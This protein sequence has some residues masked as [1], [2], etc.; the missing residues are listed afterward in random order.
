MNNAKLCLSIRNVIRIGSQLFKG[1]LELNFFK[2][3]SL[4]FSMIM[5]FV[6]CSS[7]SNYFNPGG[8][9]LKVQVMSYKA[10][11]FLIIFSTIFLMTQK[12]R[13]YWD[14]WKIVNDRMDQHL[15]CSLTSK[16]LLWFFY[17]LLLLYLGGRA[18]SEIFFRWD[19]KVI[20]TWG[21]K[22][23]EL[24]MNTLFWIRNVRLSF[25]LIT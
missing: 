12:K 21:I 2:T 9:I 15:F 22:F 11:A 4:I 18:Q 23:I 16:R 13:C 8:F 17:K 14:G 3:Y 7:Y 20:W 10:S 5:L 25:T 24:N 1:K 19:L 6:N